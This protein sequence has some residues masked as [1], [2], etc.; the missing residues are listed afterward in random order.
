VLV[1][2]Q[3]AVESGETYPQTNSL[4]LYSTSFGKGHR[5]TWRPLI[6]PRLIKVWTRSLKFLFEIWFETNLC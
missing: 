4:W 6:A 1:I 5:T 2:Q 3:V